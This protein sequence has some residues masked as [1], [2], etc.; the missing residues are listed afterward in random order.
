LRWDGKIKDVEILDSQKPHIFSSST[1]YDEKARKEREEWFIRYLN[2]YP[3]IDRDSIYEI[4]KYGNSQDPHNAYIMNRKNKVK[5]VS[6]TQVVVSQDFI[7]LD[8]NK[9]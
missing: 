6:I 2:N 5:T 8:Y 1:L 9:L 3:Q 4:H 7:G